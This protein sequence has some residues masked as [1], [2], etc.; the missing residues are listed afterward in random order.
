MAIDPVCGM[1]VD[2][3]KAAG[4]HEHR[5]VKYY[6]CGKG[7]LARFQA[8]PEKFLAKPAHSHEASGAHAMHAAHG[9]AVPRVHAKSEKPAPIGAQY[10]CPMHPEVLSP[11]PGSCPKFGMALVPV[12]GAE[13]DDSEL[14]DTTR[15][16]WVSA[17]LSVPLLFIAMAPHLGIA[18]PLGIPP[19]MRGL[20]EFALG[21]PVIL[22]GGY[23]FFHKFALSLA[24]RSPNMYTL[25]GLGV[26]LGYLYS[27]AAVFAPGV[28]PREFR[29]A[30]GEVS[31]YFEASAVIVTLVLLG[32]VMQLRALGQTSRAIHELLALAPNTALRV[33]TDG[34]DAE[35]PLAEVLVGDRLRVRPG[36]KI[37]VDGTCI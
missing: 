25:I 31:T 24:N 36:E 37:P 29:S 16:F 33:G 11:K 1:T 9:H 32:E 21:T 2:P 26:G 17:A 28:F 10:T 15:R 18:A 27:L 6:F 4:S 8:D 20:V 3:A 23:P 22:W 13:E 7:C 14:R 5:G 19:K 35:V 34:R 30:G 12:A